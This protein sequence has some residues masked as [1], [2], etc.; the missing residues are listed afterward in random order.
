[1]KKKKTHIHFLNTISININKRNIQRGSLLVALDVHSI[2]DEQMSVAAMFKEESETKIK[3]RMH[4][5]I[6][7]KNHIN[8]LFT[9]DD[10]PVALHQQ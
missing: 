4:A 9:L 3:F 5:L 1:M 6:T 2:C 10:R 8:V 7:N